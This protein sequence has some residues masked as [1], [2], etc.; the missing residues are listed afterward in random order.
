MIPAKGQFDNV[1]SLDEMRA[2]A[3]A[4]K[5][6]WGPVKAGIVKVQPQTFKEDNK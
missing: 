6:P 4:N 1:T 2:Q 5:S 3:Q